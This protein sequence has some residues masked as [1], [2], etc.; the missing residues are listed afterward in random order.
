LSGIAA[1]RVGGG[2]GTVMPANAAA[3]NIA[4]TAAFMSAS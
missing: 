4:V 2:S 3:S 1:I